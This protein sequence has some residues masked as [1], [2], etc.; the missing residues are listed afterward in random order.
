MDGAAMF[1]PLVARAHTK[2]TA[3]PTNKSIPRR[4]RPVTQQFSD[5][6]REATRAIAW[7]FSTIPIFPPDR[8]NRSPNGIRP[9]LPLAYEEQEADRL[10]DQAMRM[11]DPVN[12]ELTSGEGLVQHSSAGEEE[13]Q[14]SPARSLTSASVDLPGSAAPAIVNGVLRS[15]G[16]PLDRAARAFLEPRFS[17]DFSNVR[18][19]TDA[20]AADSAKVMNAKAYAIG[21]DIVFGVGSYAPQTR[22]GQ[23]LIAHELAHVVQQSRGGLAPFSVSNLNIQ[24]KEADATG[25]SPSVPTEHIMGALWATDPAGK[26]LQ[27]S[28]DDI[29]QGGVADC[30]LFAAMAAIVNTNPQQIVEMIHDNGNGTY[31]VTFKGIGFWSSAKQTVSADFVVGQH[32]NV[33]ARKALWPLII[34]KAYAQEKGGIG[35]LGKGGNAGGALDDMLDDGPSRFDPREKTADYIM[36]K[37][38]KGKTKKWPMTIVAPKKD[39][40]SKDKQEMADNTPGLHFWHGYAIIDVDS[41]KNRIKLFNPWGHDHPNG[42]GWMDVEQVRKFF[43]EI[44]IND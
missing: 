18:V 5:R 32:G 41:V 24:R 23:R 9:S 27:P 11:S 28:L 26:P 6:D 35:V 25:G 39:N 22:A 34:E 29:S 16:Q 15:P 8:S 4:A 36:G 33:T 17:R 38:T 21:R 31:T 2:E 30:F 19:H 3:N 13:M 43:I 12:P 40:A 14:L 10:A 42:D 20:S 1:A 44:D 7:D 37:L